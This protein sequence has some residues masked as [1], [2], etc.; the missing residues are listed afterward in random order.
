[1]PSAE[2]RAKRSV[3]HILMGAVVAILAMAGSALPSQAA[4]SPS[5]VKVIDYH[6]WSNVVSVNNG[7]VETLVVP[8]IGR[9]L[10]FRFVG[11]SEGAL[12]EDPTTLGQMPGG[13]G[14]KFFGGDRAWPSPQAVWNWPPPRGFD[15]ST[16]EVS[17]KDGVVTLVTPVDS[18]FGIRVTRHIELLPGKAA[19]RIQTIFERVAA[20]NMTNS[21]GIWVDC[22]AAITGDSRC[23]VPVPSPSIFPNGY[24][25]TGSAQFTAALPAQFKNEGGLISFAPDGQHHKLGFDGGTLVLVGKNLAFRLDAPRVA[26]AA[27]PDGNSSTEVYTAE[28]DFELEM[29]GPL[30]SLPLG[31]KMEY[32]TEYSLFH[33]SEATTDAEAKKVLGGKP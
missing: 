19:M 8:A 24:T 1:M 15:G 25:T 6:G 22:M 2:C 17:Y 20:S 26:G 12:W 11:D 30:Q 23:Y 29:M 9:V 21:L 10:Q 18:R 5:A 4:D 14:Y 27:Y 28:G 16:N 13:R 7:V 33:R 31:G 3:R 32:V